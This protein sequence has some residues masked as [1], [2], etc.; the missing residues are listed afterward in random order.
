MSKKIKAIICLM[1]MV[2]IA[3]GITA[4]S[5]DGKLDFDITEIVTDA[6][7]NTSVQYYKVET[8]YQAVLNDFGEAVTNESGETVTKE[9]TYRV[10]VTAKE[11][12]TKNEKTDVTEAGTTAKT[13]NPSNT[14]P[15]KNTTKKEKTTKEKTTKPNQ[16]TKKVKGT[17]QPSTYYT[18]VISKDLPLDPID[19][20]VFTD[21][22]AMFFLQGY[23]GDNYVVNY[24]PENT[25][26]DVI[27]YAI[28]DKYKTN[29]ITYTV[30][31]DLLT[32]KSYQIDTKTNIKTEIKLI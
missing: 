32:G 28:F 12:T 23:Y 19:E 26:E 17:T 2:V 8:T 14:K 25:K 30:T 24:Y 20:Y 10:P 7:G 3:I 1:L 5:S 21:S 13:D 6:E 18:T 31:V 15:A 29:E 22:S 4:C 9:V 16:T 11:T 27:G